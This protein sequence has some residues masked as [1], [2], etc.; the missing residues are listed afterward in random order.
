MIA[1]TSFDAQ[2]DEL[3][4]ASRAKILNKILFHITF[5]NQDS[6]LV[7]WKHETGKKKKTQTKQIP[8]LQIGLALTYYRCICMIFPG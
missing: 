3:N 6:K 5:K 2:M 8:H 7:S 1:V 4:R